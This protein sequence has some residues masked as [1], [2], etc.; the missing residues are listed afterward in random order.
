[1]PINR[2]IYNKT[3]KPIAI[4]DLI[5]LP[6]IPL[7]HPIDAYKFYSQEP[8]NQSDDLRKAISYG[9][10]TTSSSSSGSTKTKNKKKP[11]SDIVVSIPDFDVAS[12]TMSIKEAEI[13]GQ[14]YGYQIRNYNVPDVWQQTEG[15]E[16]VVAVLDTGV[17]THHPDLKDSIASGVNESD[18]QD[19]HGHG[20]VEPTAKVHTSF[21]GIEEIETLYNRV[22]KPELSYLDP[23]EKVSYWKDVED[24]G[25]KTYSV[26]EDGQ[27]NI[28][29]IT[30]VHKM[31]VNEKIVK[32]ELEGGIELRLTPWHPVCLFSQSSHNKDKMQK[33]RADSVGIGDKMGFPQG[34]DVAGYL[35]DQFKQVYGNKYKEC[36]N[37]GH[38]ST[39]Y[40]KLDSLCKKC[41]KQNWDKKYEI[42]EV[43]EDFVYLAGLIIANG[44]ISKQ[45][46]NHIEITS[47]TE[48]ILE[49][50][51][52]SAE[53][54]GLNPIYDNETNRSSNRIIVNHSSFITA[55]ENFGIVSSQ[56]IYEQDLPE[57]IGKSPY[58][59]ICSFIAGY[60]DG[61]GHIGRNNMKNRTTGVSRKFAEKFCY[62]LNSIG[63]RSDIVENKPDQRE[64]VLNDHV[65]KSSQGHNIINC[66]FSALPESIYSRMAYPDKV[67]ISRNKLKTT[68]TSRRVKNV[69]FENYDG[70]F[71]DFT[72]KN[73]HTYV[74][75]GH[76]V[77]NTHVSGIVSAGNNGF[78]IVGVAPK[79][80][81]YPIKVLDDS[82]RGTLR[83]VANGMKKAVDE[84]VDVINMSLGSNQYSE[85]LDDA[86]QYAYN[87]NVPIVCASGNSGII[88]KIVYPANIPEAI[89][90]G[91]LDKERVRANFS[92]GGEHLD[93]MAPGVS[94][95]STVLGK[96]Y[97][98]YSGTSVASP[99]ISGIVA[100]MISKHKKYGGSTPLKTVDDV[101][102]HL[103]KAS[104]DLGKE[105]FDVKNGFG[106][107]DTVTALKNIDDIPDIVFSDIQ[108]DAPGIEKRSLNEE[109]IEI[110][111][112]SGIDINMSGW[113]VMDEAGWQYEFSEGFQLKAQKRVKIRTGEGKDDESNLHWG[114][115]RAIW[116]NT[117]DTAY[118]YNKEGKKITTLTY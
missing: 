16:V 26:S 69:T 71:Y 68:E 98:R 91:A 20:C 95:T 17:N 115:S 45:S 5:K 48:E 36:S 41:Q 7:E 62:L 31:P 107:I 60:I 99:Y 10:L 54:L 6:A 15:E 18:V 89:A 13:M 63:V 112:Q 25:I 114:Y 105:D 34:D 104:V 92:Q 47:I 27:T 80:K 57:A 64:K 86:V 109:W 1:M 93:F 52:K 56:K 4:G 110:Y 22:D 53:N 50:A 12:D 24:L 61:D 14:I 40:K 35:T 79:A 74:A 84:G 37:C 73:N 28:D 38:I 2:Y 3:D 49:K 90:V 82:G 59:V 116:N 70:Y 118:L 96:E 108:G 113:K 111:N 103:R 65:I 9:W 81:I 100:L 102:E 97:N 76:F 43:N 19:G 58:E 46:S 117:G 33:K 85:I 87:R 23:N 77:S 30:H 78:G 88:G 42:F 21:C 39:H 11:N 106:Y 66:V 72:V 83:T 101:F 8:L 29:Y 51:K 67:E 55:L 44:Y 94:I 75:N 32:I